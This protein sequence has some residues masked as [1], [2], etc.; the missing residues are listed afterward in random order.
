MNPGPDFALEP[1]MLSAYL[2][3]ELTAAERV[4]VE[5]RLVESAEWRA[6]LEEVRAARAAVRNLALRD[7]PAGFWDAVLAHVEAVDVVAVAGDR[8]DTPAAVVP[9]TER[10]PRRRIAWFAAAAAAVAG[11]VVAVIAVPHRSE[12]TPNVTAVVAQHGAQGSDAGDPIS[13]L[14]PVGPLAGFRR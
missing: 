13:M 14:A 12:V 4:A 8:K 1:E 9:L 5:T 11:I 10:R 3:D 7:A 6:E 2:D